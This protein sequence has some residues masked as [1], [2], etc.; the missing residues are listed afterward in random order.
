MPPTPKHIYINI[1]A[2]SRFGGGGFAVV[3]GNLTNL[4]NLARSFTNLRNLARSFTNLRKSQA[5][6]REFREV[7]GL[8]SGI[9]G[10]RRPG[11]G[12]FTEVGVLGSGI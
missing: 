6:D 11:I 4:T 5:W 12:N 10:S 8:G 1:S 9:S 7:G 3:A 2:D